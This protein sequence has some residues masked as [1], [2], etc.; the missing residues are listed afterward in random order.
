MLNLFWIA[1]VT[2]SSNQRCFFEDFRQY[3]CRPELV[4]SSLFWLS[5]IFQPSQPSLVYPSSPASVF[6]SRLFA[7]CW[8]QLSHLVS[9]KEM[10]RMIGFWSEE[11]FVFVF[12]NWRWMA[13]F[14]VVEEQRRSFCGLLATDA[15][16]LFHSA[17]C[18][19]RCWRT[20]VLQSSTGIDYDYKLEISW[21][22]SLRKVHSQTFPFSYKTVGW[23][24]STFQRLF[25]W[26]MLYW[27]VWNSFALI[28]IY[29][30]NV[31]LTLIVICFW[32][33]QYLKMSQAFGMGAFLSINFWHHA[34]A[35]FSSYRPVI[36]CFAPQQG[37]LSACAQCL[38][39]CCLL[40]LKSM[41]L[42]HAYQLEAIYLWIWLAV[43]GG[44]FTPS[45]EGPALHVS[46]H[47]C[48]LNRGSTHP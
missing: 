7:S 13:V 48:S 42:W 31:I 15:V 20:L 17:G 45:F 8:N 16:A 11:S 41:G 19:H 14:L 10:S 44:R 40:S 18:W 38:W 23:S 1:P 39:A 27:S 34:W 3:L 26:L 47:L 9:E 2:T 29:S 35:Y 25:S 22:Y 12:G 36:S 43:A 33:L 24:F 4:S 30:L 6:T 21:T 28:E 37:S 5:Q 32:E 46:H